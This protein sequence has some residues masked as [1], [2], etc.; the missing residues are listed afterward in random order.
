MQCNANTKR[1]VRWLKLKGRDDGLSLG[2]AWPG[3]VQ[4]AQG[5]Q[6]QGIAI[7]S[8]PQLAAGCFASA[9][10]QGPHKHTVQTPRPPG[11]ISVGGPQ[12]GTADKP[13]ENKL[14]GSRCN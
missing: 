3:P 12:A 5:R 9:Q 13:R 11:A 2:L 6:S 7:A 4:L 14:P 1:Q 8:A 10:T